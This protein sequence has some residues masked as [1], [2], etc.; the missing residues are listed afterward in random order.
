[1]SVFGTAV[2]LGAG[3]LVSRAVPE[4][5]HRGVDRRVLL[6]LPFVGIVISLLFLVTG[7]EIDERFL[8][9][10]RLIWTTL[11]PVDD[12]E[13]AWHDPKAMKGSV[14]VWGN[15]GLFSFSGLFQNAAFGRYRVFVTNAANAVVLSRKRGAVVVSP[16]DPDAF[17]RNLEFSFPRLRTQPPEREG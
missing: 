3:L 9:V 5:L 7:Y 4:G 12:L 11:V 8:R 14:R 15:G 17:L 2:L 13:R 6:V 1:M 10:R 16:A